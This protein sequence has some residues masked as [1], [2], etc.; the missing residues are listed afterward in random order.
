MSKTWDLTFQDFTGK[1]P[2]A[3]RY[4]LCSYADIYTPEA[5]C[6]CYTCALFFSS[7]TLS[8]RYCVV[9]SL[10]TFKKITYQL[11]TLTTGCYAGVFILTR[12]SLRTLIIFWYLSL[13]ESSQVGSLFPFTKIW[14]L[15]LN[16][17]VKSTPGTVTNC[18]HTWWP[19]TSNLCVR[20]IGQYFCTLKGFT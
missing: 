14:W 17:K 20:N 2:S 19:P 3:S 6:I 8:T 9:A 4:N 7:D 15:K 5:E 12:T 18:R 10:N 1:T 13:S 11:V 16:L